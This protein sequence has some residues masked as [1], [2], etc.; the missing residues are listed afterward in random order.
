MNKEYLD[1]MVKLADNAF[2]ASTEFTLRVAQKQGFL[3]LIYLLWL[4]VLTGL[5]L[6]KYL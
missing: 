4:V 5:I 1:I 3:N 6:I 2:E